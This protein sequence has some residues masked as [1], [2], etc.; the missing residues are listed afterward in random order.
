MTSHRRPYSPP[1][2]FHVVPFPPSVPAAHGNIVRAVRYNPQVHHRRSIRLPAYDYSQPGA[3]FVTICTHKKECVFDDDRLRSIVE[4]VWRNVIGQSDG[5]RIRRDAKPRP[6]H[7]VDYRTGRR[8]ATIRIAAPLRPANSQPCAD[9]E[10]HRC[11]TPKRRSRPIA[12]WAPRRSG[13]G[14]TLRHRPHLQIRRR[15]SAS[16]TCVEPAAPPSGR[17]TTTSTLSATRT[18]S[19]ASANTSG[20]I[21]ENGKKT[22]TTLRISD[23]S[24]G[25]GTTVGVEQLGVPLKC[26]EHPPAES[27]SPG[28]QV[29]QP[30]RRGTLNHILFAD[31]EYP[32][33]A[34]VGVVDDVAVEEPKAGM[35]KRELQRVGLT[36]QKG[37]YLRGPARALKRPDRDV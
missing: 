1:R 23:A 2:L 12:P 34:G 32:N 11:S 37:Q 17:T 29:A 36:G 30:L 3:Y 20:T 35:R 5:R 24:R 22:R 14:L 7:R 9:G 13:T 26:L 4:E 25:T 21:H 33:H 31:I 19:F 10:P 18:I 27:P 6:R 28:V 15:Q 8:I 16:T